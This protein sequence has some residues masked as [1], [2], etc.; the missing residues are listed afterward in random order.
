MRTFNRE[1]VN[2][3]RIIIEMSNEEAYAQKGIEYKGDFRIELETKL[4]D[5]WY[6]TI[7]D[8]YEMFVYE[9]LNKFWDATTRKLTI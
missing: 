8:D 2:D 3:T 6:D 4:G 5:N 7:I 9:F 1:L